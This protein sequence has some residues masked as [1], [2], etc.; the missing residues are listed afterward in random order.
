[1]DYAGG[2]LGRLDP[3]TGSVI[4]VPLPGGAHSQPY[5]MAVDELDRIWMVETGVRPNRFLGY[6]TR[7]S[8]FIGPVDIPS[9]AGSVRHMYYDVREGVVWFGTDDNTIGRV[10]V[11]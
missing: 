6:D 9:G 5:G 1:V 2:V 8:E 7:T 3:E 10:R 11:R 4:E